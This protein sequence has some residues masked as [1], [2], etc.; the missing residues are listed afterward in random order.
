MDFVAT[1]VPAGQQRGGETGAEQGWRVAGSLCLLQTLAISAPASGL[2]QMPLLLRDVQ[3]NHLLGLQL[4]I[5][6]A[7]TAD[8]AVRE[9]NP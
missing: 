7:G 1:L 8:S 2:L 5:P 9:R 6:C 3:L 4:R